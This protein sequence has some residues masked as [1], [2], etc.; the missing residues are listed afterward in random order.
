[1]GLHAT[2]LSWYYVVWKRHHDNW[3]INTCRAVNCSWPFP[4]ILP[5]FFFSPDARYFLMSEEF[6]VVFGA[7]RVKWLWSVMSSLA[8]TNH[9]QDNAKQLAMYLI[10]LW[11][12][13]IFSKYDSR[14]CLAVDALLL[15]ARARCQTNELTIPI[16]ECR[17]CSSK[18]RKDN[19]IFDWQHR[20]EL[21]WIRGSDHFRHNY[22]KRRSVDDVHLDTVWHLFGSSSWLKEIHNILVL[23]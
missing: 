21:Q 17:V 5:D 10:W 23:R 6:G 20:L 2:N 9:G 1:M 13:I 19:P 7:G 18:L 14:W 8:S 16:G 12:T 4:S 15:V 3:I 22:E 11:I